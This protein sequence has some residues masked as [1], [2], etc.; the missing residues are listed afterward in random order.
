MVH[1]GLDK[2]GGLNWVSGQ[3]FTYSAVQDS[4][5]GPNGTYRMAIDCTNGGADCV[6]GRWFD[7]PRTL[8]F[9]FLCEARDGEEV[10]DIQ[11]ADSCT[12]AGFDG[13]G[14]IKVPT[15]NAFDYDDM[16][17]E[18]W[19]RRDGGSEWLFGHG[20]YAG[21]NGYR[22][23]HFN[24]GMRYI[25]SGQQSGSSAYIPNLDVNGWNHLAISMPSGDLF[26]NGVRQNWTGN[27]NPTFINVA[28]NL[29]MYFGGWIDRNIGGIDYAMQGR[30]A[31]ARISKGTRYTDNFAPGALV[32]D[33]NI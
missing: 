17:I 32:N 5:D 19:Y 2:R 29:N 15:A 18:L 6:N 24:G 31:S 21:D 4:D 1:I 14:L 10:P 16:T 13:G 33:G 23:S 22:V 7:N 26:V 27:Q 30:I 20:F 28:P 9:A 3:E 8:E 12:S 11:A 25:R